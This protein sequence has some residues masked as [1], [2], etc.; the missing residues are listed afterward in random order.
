MASAAATAKISNPNQTVKPGDSV[1]LDGSS[2]VGTF[3]AWW[4]PVGTTAKLSPNSN[5]NKVTFQAPDNIAGGKSIPHKLSF[6]LYVADQT[7]HSTTTATIAVTPESPP[8]PP[9]P[10]TITIPDLTATTTLVNPVNITINAVDTYTNATFLEIQIDKVPQK[11][12]AIIESQ[13]QL[14]QG[15]K[16][17]TAVIQ[18][19][20]NTNTQ[21]PTTDS[22]TYSAYDNQKNKSREA[23]VT[24]NITGTGVPPPPSPPPNPPLPPIP[25][26]PT[27]PTKFTADVVNHST[28]LTTQQ[29]QTLCAAVKKQLDNEVAQYWGSTASFN[30]GAPVSGNA[31]LGFF[32]TA[33]Q[34]GDLGWHDDQDNQVTIEIFYV[35]TLDDVGVTVSHEM[36]ETIGDYNANTTVP[37]VDPQGKACTYFTENCDPVES[38]Q[39]AVDNV[40]VSNFVTPAWFKLPS[41]AGVP[42]ARFDYL[43][44]TATPFDI[45][46]GGYMDVSYD[47]GNN[48]QDIFERTSGFDKFSGSRKR[49]RDKNKQAGVF[50]N[51]FG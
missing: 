39:Y 18:Y 4:Q 46:K 1:T 15:D 49:M 6:V 31:K 16:T 38:D 34:P 32:D 9:P 41:V 40:Q 30:F 21:V 3:F 36:I 48:W 2:S 8:P 25:P 44:K 5:S 26:A 17:T 37:A 51:R 19:Q 13:G 7:Y 11:G 22:F 12:T 43:K 29:I 42:D 28:K 33:D 23:T 45:D 24:I 50:R 27:T 35:G 10:E 14:K 47:N 20:P